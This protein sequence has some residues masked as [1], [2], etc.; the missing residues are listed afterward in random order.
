MIT[1]RG[2]PTSTLPPPGGLEGLQRD[3][4]LQIIAAIAAR[5]SQVRVAPYVLAHTM[6]ERNTDLALIKSYAV[7]EMGWQVTKAPF[8][9]AGQAPPLERRRGFAS[10]WQY[11]MQGYADGILAIARPAITTDLVAYARVLENLA[12]RRLFLAFLPTENANEHRLDAT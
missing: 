8:A 11:A 1:H 10:G 7:E 5:G 2:R 9:D 4:M 3:Y 12:E 6:G